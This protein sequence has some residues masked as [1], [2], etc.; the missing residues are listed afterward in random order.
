MR[1][2]RVATTSAAGGLLVAGT[3]LIAGPAAADHSRDLD[4]DDFETQPEAQDHFDAHS[5]DPDGLDRDDNGAACEALPNGMME[6]EVTADFVVGLTGEAEV[7]G[8]GDPDG[9]GTATLM[10]GQQSICYTLEVADIDPATAAHIHEAGPEAAG[11]V[12]VPLEEVPAEGM[13]SGC[14]DVDPALITEILEDPREHYVNVHNAEF[15]DGALRGQLTQMPV[16]GVGTGGGGTAGVEN[17]GLIAAGGL[18]LTV[19]AG[20]LILARRQGA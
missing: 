3:L 1:T 7:P 8:P 6:D 2:L 9:T 12:V 5:G 14:A 20:G 19:G 13:S 17:L 16:G 15:P 4:C 10:V 11:P 18:A